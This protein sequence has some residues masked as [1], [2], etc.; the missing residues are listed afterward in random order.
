M[1]K[2]CLSV[3]TT[4][5]FAGIC[6]AQEPVAAPQELVPQ[7]TPQ[8]RSTYTLGPGDQ[9]TI[10][11]LDSEEISEKPFRIDGSGNIRLPL[12]GRVKAS[13]LTVDQL[14]NAISER[15]KTYLI[16]PQVAVSVTEF[17]S[18]PVSVFG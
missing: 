9:L 4:L 10:S 1:Y 2:V 5:A 8:L 13:G 17:R 15:L 16:D 14:E 3:L 12:G 11:A 18:Q 7:V 6:A